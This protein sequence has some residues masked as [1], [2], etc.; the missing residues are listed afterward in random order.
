MIT[1]TAFGFF[2]LMRLEACHKG[3]KVKS[4]AQHAGAYARFASMKKLGVFLLADLHRRFTPSIKCAG[5]RLHL[6]GE[7]HCESKVSPPRTH[8]N[9]PSQCP[10]PDRSIRSPA[11]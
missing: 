2:L 1:L 7:R 6:G 10:N 5:T 4:V 8:N 11:H 9:V 3:V